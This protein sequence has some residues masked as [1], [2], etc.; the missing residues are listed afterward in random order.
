M[1]ITRRRQ[2]QTPNN[3]PCG[4]RVHGRL[5]GDRTGAED[6]DSASALGRRVGDDH[7]LGDI[8]CLLTYRFALP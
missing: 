1:P 2:P 5:W 8:R 4:G 7:A 3:Q 6:I